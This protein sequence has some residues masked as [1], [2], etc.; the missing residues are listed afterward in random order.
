METLIQ[1]Q[2]AHETKVVQKNEQEE[3]RPRLG[4][5]VL[6][7][8]SYIIYV[9]LPDN[10]EEML[11]V[12]GYT[13]AYDKIPRS[14]GSYIRSLEG[15]RAAAKP[16]YGEWMSEPAITPDVPAPPQEDIHLLQKRGYLTRLSLEQE[17]TL[18]GRV[19]QKMHEQRLKQMPS[20]I[21]MPTYDCNLRC[22]YCFQ[23]HMRTDSKYQRLLRTMSTEVADRV[24]SSMKKIE[25]LHGMEED[26]H[27][28]RHRSIGFF[29]GEPLLAANRSIVEYIIR[30]A[31]R[32]GTAR[33]WAVSNATELEAYEDLLSAEQ[34]GSVQITLDGPRKEHDQR[35]IYPD[36]SGSFAKIEQNVTMALNK[37]VSISIRMNVD[38]NNI[39]QLPKLA[40]AIHANGW[41][42]YPNFSSYTSPIRAMNEN[43]ARSTT[44]STPE[45]STTQS[46]LTKDF[47][48]VSIFARPDI[49][50]KQDARQIFHGSGG[51]NMP[52]LHESFCSAHSGM[53]IFDAFADIYVCWDKTGDA[54]TRFGHIQE[55]GALDINAQQ[56]QLWRGRTVA[57]NPVCRKCRYALH[58]G[59]GCAVL[60]YRQSGK[61]HMNYCDGFASS[62]KGRVVEAY[63]EHL[64]G[65][66]MEA[67]AAK[68]CDQ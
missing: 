1:I 10:P 40:E 13:G 66:P 57:S 51:H 8:S 18:F 60:A 68:V 67:R 34:I 16:L 5:Q 49:S 63:A 27:E 30:K 44:L 4:D 17:E 7:A 50:I 6:R 32:I 25:A 20:Y 53:Y 59:G 9:D 11:L 45:L 35:R 39:D 62:F 37:G 42:Q 55:D 31:Q 3:P 14:L 48:L 21:I 2:P 29:G 19:A 56:M 24:F 22:S 61:Y 36:G 58:C 64:A 41:D 26:Q 12:H 23:D 38:R 47:P 15:Q 28:G 33:F 54:S 65:V 52:T 46:K 43:V